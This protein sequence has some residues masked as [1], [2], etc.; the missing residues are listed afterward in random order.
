MS[1]VTATAPDGQTVTAEPLLRVTG[2]TKRFGEVLANSD[3]SFDVRPGE[4]HALIGEN[5]A[6]K[7]TLLKLIYGMYKPDSGELRVVGEQVAVGSPTQARALGIGMVFQDLRLV[8]AFTVTENYALAL[9][10]SGITIR[11]AELRR[12][13]TEASET[14]GL[15]VDPTALVRHLSIGERQRTEILKVLMSGARIVIL[16]EPTSV[17]APTEVEALFAMVNGLRAQGLGIVIVTHKLAEVRA[18]AD[19]VTVLRGGRVVLAGVDPKPMSD[20]ELVEAMVGQTVAALPAERP[21]VTSEA[22]PALE[23]TGVSALGDRGVTALLDVTLT[24]NPGEIVG[25][26]GVAGSGQRELCEVAVGA[27]PVTAGTVRVNGR[28]LGRGGP[29]AGIAAGAVDVPEDPVNDAVV[30]T[31]TVLEHMAL[32]NLRA[33]LRRIGL[34]WRRIG[35]HTTDINEKVQLRMAPAHRRVADLSGGNIQ[36]VMLSRALGREAPLVV[37][38]Y[39]SR[40]LDIAT[41]RRTQELLLARR[42]EGAGLLV[43]SEDLDELMAVADRI[44]VFCAGRLTGVVAAASTN[45]QELGA[46]MTATGPATGQP[47]DTDGN[48]GTADATPAAAAASGT[49]TDAQTGGEQS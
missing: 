27:R 29:T 24:V 9:A 8:P 34:D 12:R 37:A 48:T 39:P 42:A 45:R 22:P 49:Q 16:D 38:A 2:F 13:I 23:L 20:G 33:F 3:V 40:G 1:A 21:T 32:S 35:H 17:L 6:G 31:L 18:I 14:Y 41:T 5:G 15:A 36:R 26:A 28:E 25:V 47:A 43:V 46:L 4:V 7:S 11:Q 10:T 44:A 19:R 30:P